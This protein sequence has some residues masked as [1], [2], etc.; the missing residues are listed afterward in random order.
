M[1]STSERER[2]LSVYREHG[3]RFDA[4]ATS[5]RRRRRSTV[6]DVSQPA[7]R[8]PRSELSA[9]ELGVLTLISDGL[10]NDEIGKR[11]LIAEETVKTHVRRILGKLDAKNR[12]HAVGLAYRR[13]LIAPPLSK[14]A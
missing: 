1:M 2:L 6:L 12:A 10:S 8:V 13:G 4:I 7:S 5:R 14:A 9:R 11:L 3:R